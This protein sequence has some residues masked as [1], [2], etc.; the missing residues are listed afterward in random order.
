[1]AGSLLQEK[2]LAMFKDYEPAVREIIAEVLILEQEHLSME[3]PRGIIEK[4]EDVIDR[5]VKDE[6]RKHSD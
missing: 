5:V 2:V 6:T 3:K 1:M 4:I